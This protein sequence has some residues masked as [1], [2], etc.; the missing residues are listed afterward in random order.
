MF[1]F[2]RRCVTLA[3]ERQ[4]SNHFLSV[5]EERDLGTNISFWK[6]EADKEYRI[7]EFEVTENEYIDLLQDLDAAD[8]KYKERFID[9]F[10]KEKYIGFI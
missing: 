3:V 4:K 5:L 10:G 7:Y 8:V 9:S 1:K 6:S 2:G